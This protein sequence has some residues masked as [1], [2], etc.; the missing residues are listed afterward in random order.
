[1]LDLLQNV[2]VDRLAADVP[3]ERAAVVSEGG[4]LRYSEFDAAVNHIAE[5]FARQGH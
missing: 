2:T 3:G 1:M 5:S 4:M